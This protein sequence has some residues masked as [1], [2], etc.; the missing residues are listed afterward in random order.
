MED[1]W[2]F[3]TVI[4]HRLTVGHFCREQHQAV[5]MHRARILYDSHLVE[6]WLICFNDF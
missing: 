2:Y 1:M 3:Y 5:R 6:T 4:G